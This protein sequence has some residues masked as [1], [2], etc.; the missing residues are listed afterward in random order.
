MGELEDLV[1]VYGR[2]DDAVVEDPALLPRVAA[3]LP[4]YRKNNC[5]GWYKALQDW[6]DALPEG[7]PVVEHR[8]VGQAL[9]NLGATPDAIEGEGGWDTRQ[10]LNGRRVLANATLGRIERYVDLPSDAHVPALLTG[11]AAP[12][13]EEQLHRHLRRTGDYP[14]IESWPK[15]MEEARAQDLIP[16]DYPSAAPRALRRARATSGTAGVSA[17]QLTP[18]LVPPISYQPDSFRVVTSPIFGTSVAYRTHH[19]LTNL[20]LADAKRCLEPGRWGEY[21]P[22]WCRMEE[23]L[24]APSGGG[25]RYLEVISTNCGSNLELSTI[26]DFLGRDLSDGGGILEYRIPD[27]LSLGTPGGLVTIDEGSLEVRPG[28]PPGVGV[29]F[30]TTKRIQFD[31][32]RQM[33]AVGAAALGFLVWALGWDGLAERFI[34]FFA[35]TARTTDTEP[36]ALVPPDQTS[37]APQTQVA[38]QGPASGGGDIATLLTLGLGGWQN[39]VRDCVGSVKSSMEKAASGNYG[40]TDYLSDQTKLSKEVT[41]RTTALASW[42]AQT[43]RAVSDTSGPGAGGGGGP[44]PAQPGGAPSRAGGGTAK[45]AV[46]KKARGGT[47]KKTVAKKAVSRPTR[48]TVAKKARGGTAKKAVAKKARGGTAKM[49]VAKRAEGPTAKRTPTG[50]PNRRG[51]TQG[52]KER[53]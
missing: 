37:A 19:H 24:P 26:L 9:T 17:I 4:P 20:N 30:V 6:Q 23:Q 38:P 7:P 36:L 1:A 41:D 39:Y 46:A 8:D 42:A 53:S 47:A 14:T 48:K 51:R 22:P 10:W 43:Y 15:M 13:S 3:L 11:V 34:Y 16:A 35:R 12:G 27:G 32:F 45:K 49:T 2:I 50:R 31:P 28:R 21:R 29:H 5:A 33:P 40:V 25:H 18:H 52:N 44:Q